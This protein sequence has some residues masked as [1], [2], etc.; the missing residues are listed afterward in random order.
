MLTMHDTLEKLEYWFDSVPCK[1]KKR[2]AQAYNRQRQILIAMNKIRRKRQQEIVRVLE[3]EQA[4]DRKKK[5]RQRVLWTWTHDQE[6]APPMDEYCCHKC[7]YALGHC[8]CFKRGNSVNAL[9]DIPISTYFLLDG[10]FVIKDNIDTVRI[11]DSGKVLQINEKEPCI[12]EI[13]NLPWGQIAPKI[14]VS[15]DPLNIWADDGGPCHE[16]VIY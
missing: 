14:S 2:H 16:E 5:A 8:R 11:I 13:D 3:E 9:I 6:E 1:E 15:R 10:E 4:A 7:G 12:E